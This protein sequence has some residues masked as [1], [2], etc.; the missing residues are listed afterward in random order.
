VLSGV[1]RNVKLV[2]LGWVFMS[3]GWSATMPFMAIYLVTVRSVPYY[4]V[5]GVFLATGLLGL[6][7]QVIAGFLADWTG[8]RR[9]MLAGNLV[10]A[11]STF[12]LAFMIAVQFAA[13]F[14]ILFYLAF[15][16]L[17]GLSQPA[18]SALIADDKGDLLT[19]FSLLNMAINFGFAIGPA[20]GG[21]LINFT[22]YAYLFVLSGVLALATFFV[23]L[24]V[25][26]AGYFKAK[27]RENPR[28]D[29]ATFLYLVLTFMGFLVIGQD[30]QPFSLYASVFAGLSD[31]TIGV[32]FSFS[33]LLIVVLQLGVVGFIR[34][35]G[36]F[37]L[38]AGSLLVGAVGYFLTAQSNEIYSLF[39]SMGVITIAEVLFVVPTQ[40]WV[41]Y[42]SPDTRK[43]AFQGYFSAVRFTGRSVAAWLGT[44]ALGAY[45]SDPAYAWYLIVTIS[46]VT[47]LLFSVHHWR[48]EL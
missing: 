18:S 42:R 21:F 7:S 24:P 45:S 44:T 37:P 30:V 40:V 34:R 4:V 28:P 43:G 1:S 10:A 38:V 39:L 29:T 8:P 12:V 33:G 11:V 48:Y 22:G 31:A 9:S 20:A 6:L 23:T 41:T 17:R 36:P 35:R 47:L 13:G 26:E 3:T 32:I 27:A 14:I 46:L 16:F 25:T 5:G 15:S 19:N 2:T